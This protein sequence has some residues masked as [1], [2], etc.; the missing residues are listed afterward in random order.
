MDEKQAVKHKEELEF[1]KGD[2]RQKRYKMM[3]LIN[4]QLARSWNYTAPLFYQRGI[5]EAA[6][7]EFGLFPD[8]WIREVRKNSKEWLGEKV[9][10]V[11]GPKAKKKRKQY[12]YSEQQRIIRSLSAI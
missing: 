9:H 6:Q 12:S 3:S 7:L 2:E 1:L 10:P 11:L 5:K 4:S 8:K